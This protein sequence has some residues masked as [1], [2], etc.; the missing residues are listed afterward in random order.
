MTAR[1]A[2]ADIGA[3]ADALPTSERDGARHSWSRRRGSWTASSCARSGPATT[4]CCRSSR[5]T[6]RRRPAGPRARRAAEARLHYFLINKGP[7]SRLDHNQ[8]FVPGAPAKPEAANFYPAGATKA[9]VE[10]WIDGLPATRRPPPPASSRRSAAAPQGFT[11]VP[12]SVEYQGELARA[13]A[14]L[15]EAAALDGRADAEEVPDRAR[16][17]VPVERLL[18]QRRRLDGARRRDRADHRSV[19]GLRGRV[20]QLQGGVR[21]VHHRAR[22]GG[23]R[24]SCS[25]SRAQLQELENA[26]ADRSEVPQPASSARSR[27][28]ASSTSSSPPATAT[29]ACRPPPSTCRTTSASS[30]RRAPSA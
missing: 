23:D 7:W 20:V 4:R 8:P 19:R 11:A 13:A 6:S 3:D 27:R 21:S 30:A 12:Y 22:R 18:R 25:R 17:R 29:A 9:E 28:S 5:A 15:R 16:R 2:P 10:K 24:R 1:F 26:P 14:L